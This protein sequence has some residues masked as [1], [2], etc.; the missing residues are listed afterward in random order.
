[1]R[2]KVHLL[3]KHDPALMKPLEELLKMGIKLSVGETVPSPADYDILISGLPDREGIEASP[4]LKHLIIPWAGIPRK[5]RQLMRGYPG[6][7]VH[8]IH[9]NAVPVAEMAITLMLAAA[10]DLIAID[11]SFRKNDWSKRYDP[12][13]LK[14][15]AGKRALILGFGSIG[16]EIARRCLGLGMK[17]RTLR[18]NPGDTRS[19]IKLRIKEESGVE[20]AEMRVPTS[21]ADELHALLPGADV[22]FISVP[23]TDK[24]KG[25]LGTEELS[26]L[27]DGAILVN[28]SRGRIVDEKALYDELESGRIRAGLDVWYNYPESE[29]S[30]TRTRPSS[31][32]FHGL[33]NVV[34][35]PHLAG[36]SDN[37]EETRARHLARLLN[38]ASEGGPMPNRVDLERGY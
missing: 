12:P 29:E 5:T 10:K 26:L 24:T 33:P 1:M 9:H 38:A 27:P 2:L 11:G 36:H 25:L 35:T 34:M 16:R 32:P 22:L 23:L 14:V 4:R 18:A 17:V 28:I 8:N 15:L 20:D 7:T 31:L 21:P 30:R 19:G 6:I 37:T 3:E 13:S